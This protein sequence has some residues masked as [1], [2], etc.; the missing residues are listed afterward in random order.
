M[1]CRPQNG[2]A[3]NFTHLIHKALPIQNLHHIYHVYELLGG[4]VGKVPS[5]VLLPV[6]N[7][8]TFLRITP[9]LCTLTSE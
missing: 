3:P 9:I 6:S 5:Y 8:H 7:P 4:K 2:R 1:V